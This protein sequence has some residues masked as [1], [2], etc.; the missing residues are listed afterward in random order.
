MTPQTPMSTPVLRAGCE[1]I[2]LYTPDRSPVA[3]DLSDNT[4]RWG[5]P[6][7]AA[8]EIR[9]ALSGEAARYPD[10]YGSALKSAAA[11]YIGVSPSMVVT[12]C[13]S[14]DVLDSAIR[15]FGEPGA[16]I[17]V[18]DPTF[19]MVPIFA[20]LNG[21]EPVLVPLD[22]SYAVTADAIGETGASIVYLCSPNNPTGTLIPRATIEAV[23]ERSRGRKTLVIVDEA[24]AEFSGVSVA[25][26][27]ASDP[28][29]LVVRTMSK[30]FGLAGLRIGYAVGAPALVTGVEK[31]RG[32]FKLSA[33]A[34]RAA[35]TALTEDLEWVR[36]HA[37]LAV[38][39]RDRTVA[40]LRKRCSDVVPSSAN[41]VLVPVRHA[42]RVARSMRSLGVAVRAFEALPSISP[43]LRASG[44]GALRVSIGPW[45]EMEAALAAF[46]QAVRLVGASREE[47]PCA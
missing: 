24:Y 27:V 45:T 7:A 33:I 16:R 46:D 42:S 36:A 29:L 43:A 11:D 8:R 15:A 23:L 22:T 14:D 34:E 17:A 20:R 21:L 10:P 5:V 26:L 9:R 18:I 38:E 39:N 1:T 37:A 2:D 30:A 40:E 28:R 44:G 6:P 35:V 25:D 4:N 31:S 13:G 3:V 19:L 32:P 12:G 47:A 41:F